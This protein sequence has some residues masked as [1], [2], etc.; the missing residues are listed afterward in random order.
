MRKLLAVLGALL[1]AALLAPTSARASEEVSVAGR[2]RLSL[3]DRFECIDPSPS[4]SCTEPARAEALYAPSSPAC[5]GL[6]PVPARRF[7]RFVLGTSSDPDGGVNC[8]V[9]PAPGPCHLSVRGTFGATTEGPYCGV[10]Q[11][12]VV[13]TLRLGDE[14]VTV[15]G[16]G[17]VHTWPTLTWKVG[18]STDPLVDAGTVT[19]T[20]LG[21]RGGCGASGLDGFAPAHELDVAAQVVWR[22]H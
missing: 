7:A 10:S 19:L 15:S 2:G 21:A 14:T 3:W 9:V 12:E 20:V 5:D 18:E 13:A 22:R 17:A 16:P 11:G 8:S 1:I 4:S 6:C